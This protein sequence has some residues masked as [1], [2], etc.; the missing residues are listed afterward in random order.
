[1]PARF[2]LNCNCKL[3]LSGSLSSPRLDWA[4]GDPAAEVPV[5]GP[6]CAVPPSQ[7][8]EPWM[9]YRATVPDLGSEVQHISDATSLCGLMGAK[10]PSGK[11]EAAETQWSWPLLLAL[12]RCLFTAPI[13][14]AL[15]AVQPWETFFAFH[16]TSGAKMLQPFT[17]T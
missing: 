15:T 4:P 13:T 8:E 9:Y 12:T 2:G 11:D 14:P 16:L 6:P 7:M 17:F 1:M 5:T 3:T 10:T